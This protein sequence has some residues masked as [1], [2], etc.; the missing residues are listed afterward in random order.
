MIISLKPGWVKLS[1]MNKVG[2]INV[3]A[4]YYQHSNYLNWLYIFYL[5]MYTKIAFGESQV[6]L[7]NLIRLLPVFI[8]DEIIR[9]IIQTNYQSRIK[10]AIN[11]KHSLLSN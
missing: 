3:L 9:R 11:S 1:L 2:S 8:R 5:T 6:K 7:I 4:C 10:S